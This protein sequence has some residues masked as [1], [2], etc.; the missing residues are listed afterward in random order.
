MLPMGMVP[1][2]VGYH[3]EVPPGLTIVRHGS[4]KASRMAWQQSN[5]VVVARSL[6]PAERPHR[7]KRRPVDSLVEK[8]AT[9]PVP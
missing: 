1:R 5:A 3:V 2:G 6:G 8:G 7:G 4:P 9:I